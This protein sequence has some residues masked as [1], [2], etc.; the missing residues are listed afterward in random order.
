MLY[1]TY[2]NSPVGKLLLVSKDNQ[3]IGL[4]LENQ[5]YYLANIKEKLTLKDNIPIF[6]QTKKWLNDYFNGQKKDI[7]EL[8]LNPQG[9]PFSK[10]VW[11]YLTIIPYG[12]TTTYKEI[13]NQVKKKLQKENMSSQAIGNAISH[14]PISIIIPC[15][16]VI[17]TNNNLTGYAGGIANK[18]ELLKIEGIDTTKLHYKGD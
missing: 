6:I 10:L 1:K 15:H 8:Q 4:W 12:T 7:K 17:G 9:P 18:I 2:Y 11:H 13:A 5:K 16:R 3:L 14:N